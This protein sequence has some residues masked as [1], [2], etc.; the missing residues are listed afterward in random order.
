M[1]LLQPPLPAQVFDG[2]GGLER[3]NT[4]DMGAGGPWPWNMGTWGPQIT[5]L[6]TPILTKCIGISDHC[7]DLIRSLVVKN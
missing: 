6:E 3:P 1:P 5:L 4:D 7:C 2:E